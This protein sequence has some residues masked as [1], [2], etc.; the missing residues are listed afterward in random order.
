MTGRHWLIPANLVTATCWGTLCL[1][2]LAG[3]VYNRYRAPAARERTTPSWAW[4]AGVVAVWLVFEVAPSAT[5]S[6]L[7]VHSPWTWTPGLALLLAST[8]FTLWAR[9]AL[10]TMWSSAA[11]TRETHAL[12]TDGPYAVTRHPIYTGV[13][14]MLAGTALVNDLGPWVPVFLFGL[15]L[16]EVKIRAEERLLSRVF[17]RDYERYRQRV[18]RLL[19]DPLRFLGRRA[20]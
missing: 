16:L 20:G 5:W 8:A 4:L 10:G 2:W 1:V 11:V 7:T 12:R 19:P 18:P 9:L 3:A 6:R 13:L 17:P 14:G 15:V